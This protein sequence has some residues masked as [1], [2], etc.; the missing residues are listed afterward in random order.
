M[1]DQLGK[2][3]KQ[4][5]F[6]DLVLAATPLTEDDYELIDHK[7]RSDKTRID[8]ASYWSHYRMT[9]EIF[10]GEQ[11]DQ[12][13]ILNDDHWKTRKSYA[14]F[15]RVIDRE[16]HKKWLSDQSFIEIG[17]LKT[18]LKVLKDSHAGSAMLRHLF[19]LTPIMNSNGFVTHKEYYKKD[20]VAFAEA[21]LELKSFLETQFQGLTVRSNIMSDP[22]RQLHN[23][24]ALVGLKK[25]DL[26]TAKTFKDD[27]TEGKDAFYE[28]DAEPLE[29]MLKLHD[30]SEYR[31]NPWEQINQRYNF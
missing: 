16:L 13:L 29:R 1:V 23:M 18:K 30:L 31:K 6:I 12:D 27:G 21:C 2:K 26:R 22:C 19:M 15:S 17:V 5:E 24:L 20:L 8:A 14:L 28:L 11:V 7:L 9:L 10:Y 3:I 25:K 4:Q